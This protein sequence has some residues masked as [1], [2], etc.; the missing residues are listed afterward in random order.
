MV[1]RV[2]LLVIFSLFCFVG[3]TFAQS[4]TLLPTTNNPSP[5]RNA[6]AV[7]DPSQNRM[8]VFGG[9]DATGN[10]N[11]VWSLNLSTLAWTTITP[12]TGNVPAPRFSHNAM[13][14]SS[15]NRMLIWSG[16]GSALYNDV[17]S[18]NFAD[19]SWI[20]L[21]ANG[22]I[23]GA[24][25]TRYGTGA[26][27]D[28]ARSRLV[29]YAGFTSSG[30][31]QDTWYFETDSIVWRE[32]TKTLSPGLRCLHSVCFA[33]DLRKMIMY[34]GQ[35]SGPL[36]DIWAL[37][38]DSF[39]WSD[40]APASKPSARYFASVIYSGNGN[41]IMFG[42]QTA[43]GPSG[44]LW[45]F[46]LTNNMWQP[47]N[48]GTTKPSPRQGHTSVH[49]PSTNRMIVFG[50]TDGNLFNE[51]WEFNAATATVEENGGFPFD[52][53]LEQNFPNPFNPSTRIR[54]NLPNTAFTS[55]RVFDILGREVAVLVNHEQARG[56]Q[57]IIFDAASLPVGVYF[58]KLRQGL[59]VETKKMLF[60][61]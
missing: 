13:I 25:L 38:V 1:L 8:I 42:G 45:L 32:Q 20:E 23:S 44:E 50:G 19:S 51:T 39:E 56:I 4:W 30:R 34:G 61:K 58:Y 47:L 37:D 48:G 33:P 18:F 54:Y 14:D 57:D 9:V 26:I 41:V 59:Y 7:H 17:W 31:F 52:F 28:A 53:F 46:S 27:Y 22:N 36:D 3:S 49:V 60:M 21:W 6:S 24:P 55:L 12:S 2:K 16:Q 5:R 11:D 10:K 35:R 40:L 29:N 15:S 43:I